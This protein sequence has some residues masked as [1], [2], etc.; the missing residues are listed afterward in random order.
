MAARRASVAEDLRSDRGRDIS[1]IEWSTNGNKIAA[2]SHDSSV[3]I[4]DAQTGKVVQTLKEYMEDGVTSLAWSPDGNLIA[5]GGSSDSGAVSIWEVA[6]GHLKTVCANTHPEAVFCLKWS[7]DGA[8]IATATAD[9]MIRIWDA[10]T[11]RLHKELA[12]PPSSRHSAAEHMVTLLWLDGGRYLAS[13]GYLS[14]LALWDRSDWSVSRIFPV[15]TDF[16]GSLCA[17]PDE[18]YVAMTGGIPDRIVRIWDMVV[19]EQAQLLDVNCKESVEVVCFSPDGAV[20]AT[21]SDEDEICFWDCSD[22]RLLGRVDPNDRVSHIAYHPN[23]PILAA[24][25]KDPWGIRTY[26]G[27]PPVLLKEYLEAVSKLPRRTSDLSEVPANGPF[28]AVSKKPKPVLKPVLEPTKHPAPMSQRQGERAPHLFICH[29]SEDK[30]GFVR[31][32][33]EAL[34]SA[35]FTVWYDEYALKLGDS[36]RRAIDKGLVDCKA[37]IVVLSHAFFNKQWPQYELD[38][39]LAQEINS[40]KK[41]ILPIWHGVSHDHVMRYSPA[42]ADRV[43]ARSDEPMGTIVQKIKQALQG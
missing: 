29:A 42:L 34:S 14:P 27:I 4:W 20:L 2:G 3:W 13:G 9:P 8:L 6:P 10:E 12:G 19:G 15:N 28:A 21:E 35:G 41:V 23:A 25:S 17:S 31:G 36:L 37:G 18:R 26:R 24:A 40:Q 30:E 22:W 38:G 43:A 16:V 39:L 1:C 5:I 7:P 33:A 32:F 11:G